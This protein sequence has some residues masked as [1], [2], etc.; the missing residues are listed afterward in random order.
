GM[1]D[2]SGHA[3]MGAIAR[4]SEDD[5]EGALREAQEASRLYVTEGHATLEWAWFWPT[6][7]QLGVEGLFLEATGRFGLTAGDLAEAFRSEAWQW[8]MRQRVPVRR[9]WGALGL[10]WALLLDRLET[11]Q[12]LPRC[13]RWGRFLRGK[14]RKPNCG[15]ND[16]KVCF[17]ARRAEDQR[18]CHSWLRLRAARSS[19]AFAC[20]PRATSSAR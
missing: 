9:A 1:D 12:P 15:R 2:L 16:N 19:N 5:P 4:R 14:R 13:R 11:H 20:W 8:V 10:F 3:N 6:L 17:N 7:R 18:S